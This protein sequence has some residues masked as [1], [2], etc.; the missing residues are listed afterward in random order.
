MQAPSQTPQDSVLRRHYLSALE[1]YSAPATIAAV[2]ATADESVDQ[3]EAGLHLS[4]NTKHP[5]GRTPAHARVPAQA[6]TAASSGLLAS[7]RRL[8]GAVD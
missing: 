4:W 2:V 5:T 3:D 6:P 7:L 8:L 1:S